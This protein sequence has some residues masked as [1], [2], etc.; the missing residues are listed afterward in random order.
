MMNGVLSPLLALLPP[1][2]AGGLL[3]A[4]V[5]VVPLLTLAEAAPA[6][7]SRPGRGLASTVLERGRLREPFPTQ[8][9]Q[10]PS[11]NCLQNWGGFRRTCGG[12]CGLFQGNQLIAV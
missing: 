3:P 8:P 12:S 4:L 10:A 5:W 1:I 11:P 2:F 6:L 7:A 9:T